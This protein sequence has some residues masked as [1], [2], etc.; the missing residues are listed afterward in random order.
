MDESNWHAA[1]KMIPVCPFCGN[2][3]EDLIERRGPEWGC[4]V[5]ERQWLALNRNDH[6]LLKAMKITPEG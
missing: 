6:R 3:A 1:V 5:C 4:G 2:D